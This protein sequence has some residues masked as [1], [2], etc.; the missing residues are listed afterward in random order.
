MVTKTKLWT[1][2]YTTYTNRR[3]SPTE[4]TE[5]G[6]LRLAYGADRRRRPK[7]PQA[8]GLP[9]SSRPPA[10]LCQPYR[11]RICQSCGL[12]GKRPAA[13]GGLPLSV[14]SVVRF[15][16]AQNRKSLL[17]CVRKCRTTCQTNDMNG[18][19]QYETAQERVR[20]SG[21]K[22]CSS[23][24]RSTRTA[25][26]RHRPKSQIDLFSNNDGRRQAP[27]TVFVMAPRSAGGNSRAPRKPPSPHRRTSRSCSEAGRPWI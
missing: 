3:G 23:Y 13:P 16:S 19:P 8:G 22:R 14:Y 9:E 21:R 10:T 2:K 20:A 17:L 24:F 18:E 25:P 6:V 1:A 12:G 11:L 26:V 7:L 5:R 15:G 27:P 4:H